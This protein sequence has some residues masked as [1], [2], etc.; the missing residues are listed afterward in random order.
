MKRT[1]FTGILCSIL[2][3]QMSIANANAYLNVNAGIGTQQFLD[4][5]ASFATTLNA[6]YEF[7][8]F[9]ALDGGYAILVGTRYNGNQG[10]NVFMNVAAKGILHPT[11]D[12]NLYGRIG[13]GIGSINWT[14][15]PSS[16]NNCNN[17]VSAVGLV[18]LGIGYSITQN[19]E[20]HLED[21]AYIP[22]GIGS[23]SSGVVNML[24]GGIQINF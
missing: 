15:N 14:N 5:N 1:Y 9:F 2:S 6:G 7:N 16:N 23:Q 20:L 12:L 22:L 19:L 18:G 8:P 11:R 4:Q 13:G 10:N 3:L 17:E 24:L 21:N